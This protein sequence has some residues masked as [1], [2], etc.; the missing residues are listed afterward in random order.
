MFTWLKTVLSIHCSNQNVLVNNRTIKERSSGKAKDREREKK[1]R[2]KKKDRER[3]D[4]QCNAVSQR[5]ENSL[6]LSENLLIN[7]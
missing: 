6:P 4:M 7:Y 3:D 1:N 5:P 2:E